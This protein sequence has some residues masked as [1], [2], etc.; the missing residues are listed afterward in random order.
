MSEMKQSV[1]RNPQ[2]ADVLNAEVKQP[3]ENNMQI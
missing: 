2:V 3:G 1:S